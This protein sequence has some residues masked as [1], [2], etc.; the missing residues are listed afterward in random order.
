MS[1]M[2]RPIRL[3]PGHLGTSVSAL[4]DGQLDQE[5]T[6]RAWQHVEVCPPCRRL[7]EHEGLLKRRLAQYADGPGADLPSDRFVGAL[8][9]LDPAAVAWADARDL[10]RGVEGGRTLR[11]AGIAL[12]GAGSV[13]AAVFGLSTLGGAAGTPATS[14]GGSP[15]AVVPTRAVVAPTAD[16]RSRLPGWEAAGRSAR[17]RPAH[18]HR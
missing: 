15:G 4:V 18:A 6:E 9:D 1:P 14:I 8:R 7:V 16:V 13:S 2:R 3:L 11:R 12:V 5:S 17:P 10:E